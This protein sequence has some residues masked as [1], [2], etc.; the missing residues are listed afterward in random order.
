MLPLKTYQ[1][2]VLE[3]LENFCKLCITKGAAET[4]FL[5]Y[6]G[7]SYLGIRQLPGLPYVCLRVPT[8]GGKTLI[9]S[10]SVSIVRKEYLR[11]DNCTVLWIVP[12]N[13]IKEQTL[14]ALKDRNHPYRL[15]LESKN[16][17]DIHV[18]DL[19]EANFT[20]AADYEQSTCIIVT[21]LAALRIEDI[22]GRKIYE[23]NGHLLNHFIGMSEMQKNNLEKGENGEILYSLANVLRLR[24]PIIIMDEAHNART[25]LS[26]DSLARFSPSAIV[27]FTATPQQIHE[28][29]KGLYAS[30][31]LHSVSAAELKAE[32]MIKMPIYLE[33]NNNWQD[34]LNKAI[35]KR[36][37]LEKIAL[38]EQKQSKEYIRPILLIQAQPR[39]QQRENLTVEV[40]RQSL[41]NDFKIPEDQVK[42]QTGDIKELEDI[43]L[44][45]DTCDV[46]YII[47]VQA[48]R[49]GWDCSFAYVLCSIPDIGSATAAEQ[50]IGRILR[51]PNA[52][53]KVNDELNNAYAYV[54][55]NQFHQTLATLGSG[56]I[57]N[58]FTEFEAKSII[59][60]MGEEPNLL[61]LAVVH[62]KKVNSVPDLNKLFGNLVE[63]VA[64]KPETQEIEVKGFIN[65]EEK[66]QIQKCFINDKDKTVVET[67]FADIKKKIGI[68][69]KNQEN[70][71]MKPTENIL[72]PSLSF[73]VEG[74]LQIFE[75]IH[76]LNAQWDIL[77]YDAKLDGTS[78]TQIEDKSRLGKIEVDTKGNIEY[79]FI[80]ELHEQLSYLVTD[81]EWAEEEL[82]F[83]LDRNVEHQ[84]ISQAK[85]VVF[86]HKIIKDLV[87]NQKMELKKIVYYKFNLRDKIKVLINNYR[88]KARKENYQTALLSESI[89]V[90][91]SKTFTF[92]PEIYP[93][94]WA[95]TGRY[96]FN[97]HY[98]SEVGE[99]KESG[100]EFDCA[101]YLD[102]LPE[103]KY[104]F[105]NLE[106]QPLY[107]FWLQTSTDKFYPDFVALL[108]D[109]R[110]LVVEYKGEPWSQTLDSDEKNV[111]GK[112]WSERS[113]GNC[114][115][116]MATKDNLGKIAELVRKR[117]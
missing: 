91:E 27:E 83:W 24:R 34:I 68:T 40:V 22:N 85:F 23:S 10:H 38:N 21:T 86:V 36:N 101:V 95:Y 70:A 52:I 55:S 46:R 93:A 15:A 18:L 9:A 110:I 92:N 47:T 84:D 69:T 100:E 98:F 32:W 54:V 113:D 115:F 62:T 108:E 30:N 65:E 20:G 63:K 3:H 48:L 16:D 109:G 12:T 41:I 37:D 17:G 49:E 39:S 42:I 6:T 14:K 81:K 77:K 97:K 78:L 53:K 102:S 29:D 44:F 117:K 61:N 82:I 5:E 59:K 75:D 11:I 74:Q 71:W 89:T 76:F 114:L 103:V 33:T 107:S 67:I 56:L 111:L 25:E 43:D 57:E 50:L 94:N 99:L 90:D 60:S 19:Q 26:F 13:Q 72:V 58:G 106:R 87:E 2:R 45:N 51:L 35:A 79:R 88:K 66:E 8:G 96:K 28:P 1:E 104:W 4:A 116:I 80:E 73:K 112:F 105:R 7:R 64:Y 31:V